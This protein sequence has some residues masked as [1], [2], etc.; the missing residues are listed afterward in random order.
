MNRR[1]L[2]QTLGYGTLCSPLAAWSRISGA[3]SV[4]PVATVA[5]LAEEAPDNWLCDL[6][7]CG[8]P[9][10]SLCISLG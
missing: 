8:P 3:L 1:Q 4:E 10:L 7:P 9:F 5:T 2:L 6:I